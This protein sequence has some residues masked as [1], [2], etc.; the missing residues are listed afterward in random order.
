MAEHD[1][2][3]DANGCR[4]GKCPCADLAGCRE[5]PEPRAHPDT[6]IGRR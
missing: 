2:W 1:E 3:C 5:E 6:M 4:C